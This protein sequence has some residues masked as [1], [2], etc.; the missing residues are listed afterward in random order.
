M[1]DFNF[2]GVPKEQ[3]KERLLNSIQ[4]RSNKDLL[5]PDLK[6]KHI[7]NREIMADNKLQAFR[8]AVARSNNTA[9]SIFIGNDIE[10]NADDEVKH[11]I[12]ATFENN[13]GVILGDHKTGWRIANTNAEQSSINRYQFLKVLNQHEANK[14]NSLDDAVKKK[15]IKEVKYIYV[16]FSC[17][18]EENKIYLFHIHFPG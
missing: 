7:P 15:Y 2:I 8:K 10:Q 18:I 12:N 1:S 13:P 3:I 14:C 17:I 6:R 4:G 9:N 5:H 11:W 16:G